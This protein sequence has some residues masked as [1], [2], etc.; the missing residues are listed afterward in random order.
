MTARKLGVR[1]QRSVETRTEEVCT[2][3]KSVLKQIRIATYYILLLKDSSD[4]IYTILTL[5][6]Q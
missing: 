6:K 5:L 2:G 4:F 1:S 3:V